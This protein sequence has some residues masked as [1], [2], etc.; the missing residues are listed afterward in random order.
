MKKILCVFLAAALLLSAGTLFAGNLD[1]LSN[2]SALYVQTLN[3]NAA[4][5]GADIINF[6]PAGTAFLP[7]GLHLDLSNQVLFKFYRHD[8]SGTF[9]EQFGVKDTYK[10]AMIT[11][12]LPNFYLSYNLGTVGVGRLA[13]NLQAGV[14]AGGG[15]LDYSDG[16]AGSVYALNVLR[17]SLIGGM[18]QDLGSINSRNF[19]ASSIYYGVGFGGAYSFLHDMMSV[20]LGVRVV[21]PRRSF[22]MEGVYVNAAGVSTFV[23]AEYE[24]DTV[25]FTPIVGFDLRLMERLTIGLRWEYE[26]EL[27]F[28][29]RQ[30]ELNV[31]GANP[32]LVGGAKAG[33]SRILG[34]SGITDGKEFNNNLPHILA[35]GVEYEVLSGLALDASTSVYFLPY[36]DLEGKQ[37]YFTMGYDVG[38]GATWRI[39][40]PLKIGAGFSFTES[41]TIDSYYRDEVLNASANPPLDSIA[42]GAGV[43]Y[44]FAFG[45]DLNLGLLYSHYLPASYTASQPKVITLTGENKKDVFEA[46]IG[47]SFHL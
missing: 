26:T 2:Q 19:K 45:L 24:Y 31:I 14:T 1:Y 39:L 3:R 33:I 23:K 43:T 30:K 12:F 16:T 38:L 28:K 17:G 40:K 13:F 7:K 15:E 8:A 18:G 22:S 37:K 36:A 11:P 9:L 44:S 5:D 21:I 35:A 29:Y 20:S 34:A 32:L 27:K 10:P 41:G 47:V 6:N 25:G 4:T 42:F 46:A